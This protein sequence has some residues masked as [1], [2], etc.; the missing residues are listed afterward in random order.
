MNV[1]ITTKLAVDCL[2]IQ[3][4]DEGKTPVVFKGMPLREFCKTTTRNWK[5]RFRGQREPK[6]VN[7]SL[8]IFTAKLFVRIPL[9]NTSYMLR[10]TQEKWNT[11]ETFIDMYSMTLSLGTFRFGRLRQRL[12]VRVF[13]CIPGAHARLREAVTS[14]RS[15]FKISSPSWRELRDFQQISSPDYD[16]L[17]C[18]CK[19]E[20]KG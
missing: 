5:L 12:R 4:T 6:T 20:L 13:Q 19:G 7:L 14:T 3:V 9:Y 10:Y 11:Q 18:R 15:V 1:Q 16:W 17:H 8:S 2:S